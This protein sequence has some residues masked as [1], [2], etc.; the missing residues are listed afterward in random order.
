MFKIKTSLKKTN[1]YNTVV[2]PFMYLKGN[3][4]IEELPD[5]V[6]PI[7]LNTFKKNLLLSPY[8]D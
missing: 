5:S 4:P 3:V 8:E 1:V 2:F 6:N 7:I